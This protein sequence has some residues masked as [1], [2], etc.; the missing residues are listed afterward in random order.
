[1]KLARRSLWFFVLCLLFVGYLINSAQ[2]TLESCTA[3]V[4][5]NSV[6]TSTV[7]DYRF[8]LNNASSNPIVFFRVTTPSSNFSI[9]SYK[10]PGWSWNVSGSSSAVFTGGNIAPG[11]TLN[12]SIKAKTGTI[13]APAANW[14]VEANDVLDDQGLVGCTGSLSTTISG[15]TD[16]K[17]P[18]LSDAVVSNVTST[19]VKI[20]WT[21]D[22]PSTTK[23]GY[24][25]SPYAGSYPFSHEDASLRTSHSI[26]VTNSIMAN[27]TYYYTICSSDASGNE[28][29][30]YENS[31]TTATATTTPPPQTI[32]KGIADKNAPGV[33]I[34]TKFSRSFDQP[35][36][37][38]GRA[39][40]A[41]GIAA[42]GYSTD[43]GVNWLPTD[44][45]TSP[46]KKST[47]FNF[48][49]ILF[50]DGNYQIVVRATDGSGNRGVSKIY[51]LVIDR[52][53]PIVGSALISIGPLVLT[54]N[55][56]GQLVTISGV[57]HKVIL[58]A[59]GG[60][61]TIDLLIDNHV[62][63]FS[64][65]HETGLWNGAVIFAQSGF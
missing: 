52:L 33:F 24:G 58:S 38:F 57:E 11:T 47:T 8:T 36:E 61:V 13:E 46:G 3:S 31:F 15:V 56:N 32:I 29:C 12:F 48:V 51:T 62:H 18:V 7:R 59:A 22:E 60:P 17:L 9:W 45:L 63:S 54:P 49:P 14:K 40:D 21:T 34:S 4:S 53:P 6:A 41:Y 27:T 25:T 5:P 1:M 26:K 10:A 42:V 19:S 35:P 23:I 55:E 30:S 50:D 39:T 65:S 37:I 2:A 16:I 28:S 43:G 64:R 20:S 44:K